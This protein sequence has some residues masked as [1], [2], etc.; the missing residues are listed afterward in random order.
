MGNIVALL[1]MLVPLQ[2]YALQPY[3]YPYPFASSMHGVRGKKMQGFATMQP[4]GFV[5]DA[6]MH[7]LQ[8]VAL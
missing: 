6:S 2:S 8:S 7:G 4:D 1:K 5:K 3:A